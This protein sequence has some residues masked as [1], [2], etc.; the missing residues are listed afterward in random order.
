MRTQNRLNSPAWLGAWLSG[1][2]LGVVAAAVDGLLGEPVYFWWVFTATSFAT[3]IAIGLAWRLRH[4][5][6]GPSV[7]RLAIAATAGVI[8]LALVAAVHGL[9][10]V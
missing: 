1:F 6:T 8:L 10:P 7:A 3:Y 2:V 9:R 5:E 4:P